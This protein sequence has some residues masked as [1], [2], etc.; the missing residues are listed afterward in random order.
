MGFANT[1]QGAPSTELWNL[2][3]SKVI[4]LS[5]YM[6]SILYTARINTIGVI[7]SSDKSIKPMISWTLDK[8]S[9]H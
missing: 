4:Q 9:I 5:S 3:E 8:R 6:T 1:G 7:M 2:M